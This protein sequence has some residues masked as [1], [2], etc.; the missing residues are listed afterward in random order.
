MLVTVRNAIV[1]PKDEISRQRPGKEVDG[2]EYWSKK[3]KKHGRYKYAKELVGEDTNSFDH[4]DN[5][6]LMTNISLLRN[7]LYLRRQIKKNT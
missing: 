5:Q 1:T 3:V 4:H 2:T 7:T 6:S